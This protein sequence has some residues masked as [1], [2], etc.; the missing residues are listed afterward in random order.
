MRVRLWMGWAG[1]CT[2]KHRNAGKQGKPA[3]VGGWGAEN[4]CGGH[5]AES[6]WPGQARTAPRSAGP[7]PPAKPPPGCPDR[8]EG[9]HPET[10]GPPPPPR[11]LRPP[12]TTLPGP[13]TRR[14]R[15]GPA[16]RTP[17]PVGGQTLPNV[18]IPGGLPGPGVL[19]QTPAQP[20]VPGCAAPEARR[21]LR[22][23]AGR[24]DGGRTSERAGPRTA[25][26]PPSTPAPAPRAAA[27]PPTPPARACS[28]S[29]P[30]RL[31]AGPPTPAHPGPPRPRPIP[32]RRRFR[33]S[34]ARTPAL[35]APCP[36]HSDRVS[37][38][39]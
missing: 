9:A 27:A 23:D 6:P 3:V 14:P 2:G 7:Q 26:A 24:G 28:Q 32:H 17:L 20:R 18:R 15:P 4:K 11:P 29:P 33:R 13:P 19:A 16:P 10:P 34:A 30:D 22:G 12:A 35:A 37:H 39:G 25:A 1:L 5:A 38:P 21:R 31:P 8:R 36:L